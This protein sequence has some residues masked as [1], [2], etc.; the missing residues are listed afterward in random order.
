M[1]RFRMLPNYFFKRVESYSSGVGLEQP[2]TG[3]PLRDYKIY[4]N[5]IDGNGVGNVSSNLA[6]KKCVVSRGAVCETYEN[7]YKLT[8]TSTERYSNYAGFKFLVDNPWG[9]TYT[10]SVNVTQSHSS[11]Q[12]LFRVGC[13]KKNG[14]WTDYK[15]PSGGKAYIYITGGSGDRY[16][17]TVVVPE[18][19][20]SDVQDG[21][22]LCFWFNITLNSEALD[23][24]LGS[25]TITDITLNEGNTALDYQPAG[26][27]IIPL[28]T[29]NDVTNIYLDSPLAT[30]DYVDFI[31]QKVVKA[32]GTE[33][34]MELPEVT[35][36]TPY[37]LETLFVETEVPPSKIYCEYY[38]VGGA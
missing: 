36:T 1:N 16:S 23:G 22:G 31:N 13:I 28:S 15:T 30:G 27:Y 12:T 5:S 24:Y 10:I 4:G 26:K 38:T 9:K 2:V 8:S 17:L 6:S 7:G 14:T 37:Y 11:M 21:C 32:D 20:H 25:I 18:T 35:P 3:K 29:Y 34:F 33:E 19:P